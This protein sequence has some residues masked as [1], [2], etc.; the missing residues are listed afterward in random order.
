MEEN[1]WLKE[2]KEKRGEY[3]ISQN[4]LAVASGITRQYLSDIETG[5]VSPSTE[6]QVSISKAL[7][8]FNP[9]SPLE[10]LF[11]YVRIRF[12]T[13]DVKHI[14][15][16]VL[17]LKLSYML[18]K[19]YGFYSYSEHYCMGDIFILVSGE[20]EKGVLVELKGRGC[21][22]FENYL[23]AQERSWYEFF[24]DAL[25]EDGVMKRL[26]LA[27]N[28]KLG[29]LNIPNL[30]EK[31]RNEECVSVFRSFKNYRSGELVR[32]DE[33]ECMGN[34]L[35]I[36]SLQSEVYFCIYEKDYEQYKKNNIPIEDAEVKN[37]FE[38]RLKNERAYYAIRDLMYYDN[39]E[40]T[41]FKIINRYVRFV[42]KEDKKPRSDW[43]V[44]NEWAWF[45]GENRESMNLTTKPEPYSFRKTLNWI[46][47]QVAPTLKMAMKL[48]EINNT[49]FINEIITNAELKEKHEKILKQ[50]A[51]TAKE[52]ITYPE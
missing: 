23:L 31:C 11:D 37:R 5:K 25:V 43:K 39:P 8:R 18:H 40:S 7:E 1:S 38:I 26:D 22:Q 33:K 28:D 49:Q 34:T 52:V 20:E 44:N 2:L 12:P 17:R 36:G 14:V 46:S 32:K 27:I 4:K 51:A 19:D 3:G 30:T 21:R 24:M 16:D 42:D 9:D 45:L 10:M 41:A 48:D 50:Q 35:Y 6:L 13:L 47:R 15:E 29:I